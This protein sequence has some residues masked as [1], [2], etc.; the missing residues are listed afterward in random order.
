MSSDKS[1]FSKSSDGFING[2]SYFG[3]WTMCPKTHQWI[4]DGR[5]I[6]VNQLKALIYMGQIEN[7][8]LSGLGMMIPFEKQYNC[9]KGHLLKSEVPNT[10][11]SDKKE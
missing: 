9:P 3:E 10:S 11:K 6:V 4:P 1:N 8:K 2:A 5:G 7:Q